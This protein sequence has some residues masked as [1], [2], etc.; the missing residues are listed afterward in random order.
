MDA[1]DDEATESMKELVEM[2][3]LAFE[4][5]MVGELGNKYSQTYLNKSPYQIP[6]QSGFEWVME[7]LD[8]A[9]SSYKM[10]RMYPDV[11]MSLHDLLVSDYGLA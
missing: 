6:Q 3:H 7:S 5:A 2:T 10:F 9:K 8:H 4:V 1:S 11:F